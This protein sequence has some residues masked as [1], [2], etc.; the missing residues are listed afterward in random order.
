MIDELITL[1]S[2]LYEIT[3][4]CRV[5]YVFSKV[6]WISCCIVGYH[7]TSVLSLPLSFFTSTGLDLLDIRI[8]ELAV[9]LRCWG[10][11]GSVF[12][13]SS[14]WGKR[15]RRRLRPRPIAARL[16]DAESKTRRSTDRFIR[17]VPHLYLVNLSQLIHNTQHFFSS[18]LS[19]SLHVRYSREDFL[20]EKWLMLHQKL[21]SS[22]VARFLQT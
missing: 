8:L 14:Q 13:R 17:S 7:R 21:M 20:F 3:S 12:L 6:F 19:E 5:Q 18:T 15:S 22:I 16:I 1:R 10:G 11:G 4:R 2:S 9:A